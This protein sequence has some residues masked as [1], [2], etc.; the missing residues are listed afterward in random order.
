MQIVIE[1]LKLEELLIV[2]PGKRTYPMSDRIRAVPL[3][4]V[5]DVLG[6]LKS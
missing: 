6:L 1:D 5:S 4:K 3:G 2:Y